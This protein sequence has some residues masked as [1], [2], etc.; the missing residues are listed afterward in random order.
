MMDLPRSCVR[1]DGVRVDGVRV[2]V[3]KMHPAG[4]EVMVG[5]EEE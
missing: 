2:V 5:T 4:V 1:V 3:G